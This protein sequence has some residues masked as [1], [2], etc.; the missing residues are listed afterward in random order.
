MP[1]E[2]ASEQ[3]AAPSGPWRASSTVVMGAIGLLCGGFLRVL[4]RRE[5]HGM[6]KFLEL[7]DE[8]ADVEGRERGLITGMQSYVEGVRRFN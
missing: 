4:S 6:D 5:A 8:R 7:L 2:Q 1:P 3:P